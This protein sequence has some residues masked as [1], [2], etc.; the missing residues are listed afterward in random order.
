MI[1]TQPAQLPT[2]FVLCRRP[3][4]RTDDCPS[5]WSLPDIHP[6]RHP[7]ASSFGRLIALSLSP[8]FL[9]AGSLVVWLS[10]LLC[11]SH[12]ARFSLIL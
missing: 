11:P 5:R 9:K 1:L 4:F 2:H 8:R 7:A 10:G 3:E 6:Q 12:R